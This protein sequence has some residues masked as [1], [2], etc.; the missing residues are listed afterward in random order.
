MFKINTYTFRSS[1]SD[2]E[3]GR[4]KS[5][6]Y[7]QYT[8]VRGNSILKK[9]GKPTQNINEISPTCTQELEPSALSL[10]K[11][12]A[13]LPKIVEQC[14]LSQ[15]PHTLAHYLYE[16]GQAINHFYQKVRIKELESDIKELYLHILQSSIQA[17]TNGLSLLNIDVPER[18]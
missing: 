6:A 13:E 12:T 16:L 14:A 10:L 3:E 4:G 2:F 7:L 11:I 8:C 18:M 15:T 9:V 1:S 5:G 17:L